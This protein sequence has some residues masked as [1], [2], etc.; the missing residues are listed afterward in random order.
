MCM[1]LTF[2]L[3]LYAGRR[4]TSLRRAFFLFMGTFTWVILVESIYGSIPFIDGSIQIEQIS[5]FST[6]RIRQTEDKMDKM[7]KFGQ[8]KQIDPSRWIRQD[9]L[10]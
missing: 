10:M 3:Y 6:C 7:E 5:W 8:V 9:G 2:D 4:D 1:I